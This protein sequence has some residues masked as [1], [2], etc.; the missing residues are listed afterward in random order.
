[1]SVIRKSVEG[2]LYRSLPNSSGLAFT[3]ENLTELERE[4]LDLSPG[5]WSID[6]NVTEALITISRQVR[7]S[8]VV[9]VGAGYSTLVF[10]LFLLNSEKDF[11]L[12][13]IEENV[14]WFNIPESLKTWVSKEKLNFEVGDIKFTL[15]YFGIHAKYDLRNDLFFKNKIDLVFIDGPQYYFGREGGLDHIYENLET[16]CLIILDDAERYTEKCVIYKWLLVYEGLELI[17][18]NDHFGDKGLAVL[19]V[20][21]SLKKVFSVK[22]FGLGL[23]QGVKRLYNMK[24]IARNQNELKSSI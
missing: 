12:R 18:L 21:R 6:K 10:Y 5:G 4:I 16:G 19:R 14:D 20:N 11:E 9:E 15:S 7:A 23:M 13:S 1:M 3:V 24:N 22:A 8:T 17:Y 2:F